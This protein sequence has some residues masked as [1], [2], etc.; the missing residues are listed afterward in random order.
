MSTR[1]ATIGGRPAVVQFVRVQHANKSW[2]FYNRAIVRFTDNNETLSMGSAE[3]AKW[4]RRLD[5]AAKKEN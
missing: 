1:D 2:G 5:R 3:F 4:S